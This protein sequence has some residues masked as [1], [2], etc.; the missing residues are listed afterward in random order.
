M[1]IEPATA[2]SL[3]PRLAD[4]WHLFAQSGS[5]F[6]ASRPTTTTTTRPTTKRR[7]EY[8]GFDLKAEW[9]DM[10]KAV[11]CPAAIARYELLDATVGRHA[12]SLTNQGVSVQKRVGRELTG[13]DD[14]PPQRQPLGSAD[15]QAQG[16]AMQLLLT[17]NQTDQMGMRLRRAVREILEV[18]YACL[19]GN[20]TRAL[21]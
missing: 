17:G 16:R 11:G 9:A 15:I 1:H 19:W 8:V 14:A 6:G 10:C 4:F 7:L 18:D 21:A 3:L 5:V 20:A 13:R 12:T 2:S